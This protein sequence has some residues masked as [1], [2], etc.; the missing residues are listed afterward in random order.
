MLVK[1]YSHDIYVLYY[2]YK[3]NICLGETA[4]TFKQGVNVNVNHEGNITLKYHSGWSNT[5]NPLL[6]VN[7]LDII[8]II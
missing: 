6:L 7:Q 8:A 2:Y 5:I 1:I 3:E 4:Y